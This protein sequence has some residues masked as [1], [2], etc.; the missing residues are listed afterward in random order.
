MADRRSE[1][2]QKQK[3][4]S[5]NQK[6]NHTKG[7]K[8]TK[9]MTT[10]NLKQYSERD[11]FR[12]ISARTFVAVM[13]PHREIL[14]G[15]GIVLPPIGREGELDIKPMGAFCPSPAAL[16]GLDIQFSLT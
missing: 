7:T 10:V 9:H 16:H 8:E 2:G 15:R 11:T 14:L 6:K 5:G 3:F 12:E 1:V 13:N 4:G